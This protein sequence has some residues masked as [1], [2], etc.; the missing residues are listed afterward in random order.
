[1]I[2]G[3]VFPAKKMDYDIVFRSTGAEAVL[4]FVRII[5]LH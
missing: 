1:L 4:S 3:A 5:R 2:K